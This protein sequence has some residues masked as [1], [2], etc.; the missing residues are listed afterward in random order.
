[1]KWISLIKLLLSL[2]NQTAYPNTVHVMRQLKSVATPDYFAAGRDLS[3]KDLEQPLNESPNAAPL[4]SL[5]IP[6]QGRKLIFSDLEQTPVYQD[7]FIY[8]DCRY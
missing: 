3:R 1:M 2:E 8:R 4:Y 5:S 7:A 6:P